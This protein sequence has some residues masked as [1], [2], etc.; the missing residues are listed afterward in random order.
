MTKAPNTG[1]FSNQRGLM[2]LLVYGIYQLLW[3]VLLPLAFI[4]LWWRGRFEKGYRQHW[5]ERLGFYSNPGFK[6]KPVWIHAV[7][8]G[9]TRA[10][11][12]LIEALLAQGQVI[13]LTH[14]T[15][16]G[17]KTGA[18]L[19]A[20]AIANGSLVQAYLPYDGCGPVA[21]FLA[22]FQ[23]LLGAVMETEAWPTLVFYSQKKQ[24]PLLLINGRLSD[25]SARRIAKFGNLGRQLFQGF[26]KVLAQTTLDQE[27]YQSLGVTRCEVTGNLKFDVTL[28]PEAINA[29]VQWR[30]NLD[31]RQVVCAASTREGEEELILEAWKRL[32]HPQKPLLLIVPRHP[33]RFD[34]VANLV[35]NAGFSF[36]RKSQTSINAKIEADVFIGDSM[37]EMPMYLAMSD[38]VL[39]GGSLLPF[40]GQNLIEPCA[41]AKPVI[42]G[43]HTFNFSQASVDALTA[44][45]AIATTPEVLSDSL[46]QWINN[47]NALE[48]AS[49]AALQFAN[50]YRGATERTMAHLRQ[51]F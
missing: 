40:G 47:P 11:T 49:N 27:R 3:F 2:F 7:S 46:E 39:M 41:L 43:P 12:P 44:G 24:F 8:V 50:H 34:E 20:N 33:Q 42:L 13:V 1:S 37:G 22:H 48:A 14:M 10:A 18:D 15:P 45:A 31:H 28:N 17:R 4:R 36:V 6:Q 21:R 5:A 35:A 23:P 19:F 30:S 26:Y 32:A 51:L 16:T 38:F 29:G 25:R 9:E